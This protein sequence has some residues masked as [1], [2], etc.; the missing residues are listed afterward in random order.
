M[1]KKII[2]LILDRKRFFEVFSQ[3]LEEE[4]KE[5]ANAEVNEE[6]INKK[7][8]LYIKSTE[9]SYLFSELITSTTLAK[10]LGLDF[11][12]E[13]KDFLEVHAEI[14]YKRKFAIEGGAIVEAEK[15][16]LVKERE[17]LLQSELFKHLRSQ[18]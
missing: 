5:V 2:E 7:L 4:S 16:A 17:K 12:Q 6:L 8:D 1:D 9:A 18:Q 10:E 14:L 11:P 13:L 3:K 15:G